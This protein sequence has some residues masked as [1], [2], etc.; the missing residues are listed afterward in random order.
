MNKRLSGY[1][2]WIPNEYDRE[3]VPISYY[4]RVWL[5]DKFRWLSHLVPRPI[6]LSSNSTDDSMFV[7]VICLHF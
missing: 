2:K 7:V 4:T 1:F 3:E 5:I 6:Q